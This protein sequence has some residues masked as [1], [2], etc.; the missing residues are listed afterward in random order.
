MED[1]HVDEFPIGSTWNAQAD[2]DESRVYML[3]QQGSSF[4][5][6]LLFRTRVA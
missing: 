3:L 4:E 5:V 2:P 6:H 1:P